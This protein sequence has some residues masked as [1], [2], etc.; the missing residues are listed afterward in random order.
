M[1]AFVLLHIQGCVRVHVRSL[2]KP[3]LEEQKRLRG[4]RKTSSMVVPARGGGK[5]SMIRKSASNI[6]AICLT[7]AVGKG[8]DEL[9]PKRPS[10]LSWGL[11]VVRVRLM[12][13]WSPWDDL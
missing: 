9:V 11:H 7:S 3:K 13:R 1:D 10:Y 5:K 12:P 4:H 8:Q 2:V 6:P